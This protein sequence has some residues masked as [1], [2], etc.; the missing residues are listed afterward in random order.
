[1]KTV[2]MCETYE[3]YIRPKGLGEHSCKLTV[4][5][6][7]GGFGEAALQWDN[8]P[9]TLMC[10]VPIEV[11]RDIIAFFDGLPKSPHIADPSQ[12]SPATANVGP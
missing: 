6:G 7:S 11:L 3:C 1:M 10:R 4:T 8:E 2:G 9:K 12:P 5:R